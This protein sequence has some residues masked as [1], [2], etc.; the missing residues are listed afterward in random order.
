MVRK[1]VSTY[2]WWLTYRDK[3][4]NFLKIYCKAERGFYGQI[5]ERDLPVAPTT[6]TVILALN[7]ANAL[8]SDEKKKLVYELLSFQLD[9]DYSFCKNERSSVWATSWAVWCLL[10][11]AGDPIPAQIIKALEWLLSAQRNGGWGFDKESLPRPFY[12]YYA[13][14]AIIAAYKRLGWRRLKKSIKNVV[15]YIMR[16]QS[17]PGWWGSISD[18]SMALMALLEIRKIFPKL[19]KTSSIEVGMQRLIEHLKNENVEGEMWTEYGTPLFYIY[20]FTPA[21]LVLL[22]KYGLPPYDDL[23]IRFARWFRDNIVEYKSSGTYGWSGRIDEREPCSWATALGLI[24]MDMWRRR[25]G[26]CSK[27]ELLSYIES[28]NTSES[29]FASYEQLRRETEIKVYRFIIVVLLFTI[30]VITN[31]FHIILPILAK[32]P[33]ATIL[34]TIL[35]TL[36]SVIIAELMRAVARRIA[37]IARIMKR[38]RSL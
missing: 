23:C 33:Y 28:R 22:L 21:L 14:R 7:Y 17:E 2:D 18:T 37:H 26:R 20:F 1:G 30:M 38:K 8:S 31:P 19:V 4:I 29:I 13:L 35:N 16:A 5:P 3:I 27:G 9:D 25:V 32:I 12:T 36:V 15:K 34:N 11:V 24:A 6:A 10:E